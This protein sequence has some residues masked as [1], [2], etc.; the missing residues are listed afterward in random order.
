M[1]LPPLLSLASLQPNLA[2]IPT[3]RRATYLPTKPLGGDL[4]EMFRNQVLIMSEGQISLIQAAL[5]Q[6]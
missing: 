3:D 1:S 2:Y 6:P 5:K 4:G